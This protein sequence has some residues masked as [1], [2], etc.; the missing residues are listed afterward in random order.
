MPRPSA[1]RFGVVAV[2][3]AVLLVL[4]ANLV[5]D[6]AGVAVN[7]WV[8]LGTAAVVGVFLSALLFGRRRS[9]FTVESREEKE[10]EEESWE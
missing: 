10:A 3:A 1:R 4:V 7:W 2:L 8:S 6:L 9:A 5:A